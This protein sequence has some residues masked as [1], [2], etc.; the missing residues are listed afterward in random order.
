MEFGDQI[1]VHRE[2]NKTALDFFDRVAA[3]APRPAAP[4]PSEPRP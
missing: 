3:S 1:A 2:V 4:R